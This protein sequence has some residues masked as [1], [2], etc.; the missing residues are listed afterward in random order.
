MIRSQSISYLSEKK[1]SGLFMSMIGRKSSSK[2]L[3]S[4]IGTPRPL[5]QLSETLN[6]NSNISN[7]SKRKSMFIPSVL[8]ENKE[9]SD[10]DT[11]RTPKDI[12]DSKTKANR[13]LGLVKSKTTTFSSEKTLAGF[14]LE[15]SDIIS[16]ETIP[17]DSPLS[18]KTKV[19]YGD[20]AGAGPIEY[21][22]YL[23]NYVDKE[24]YPV[25]QPAKLHR[26]VNLSAYSDLMNSDPSRLPMGNR[27]SMKIEAQQLEEVR[28]HFKSQ[29][30]VK[31]KFVEN[32]IFLSFF[33]NDDMASNTPDA[34]PWDQVD[35]NLL[36][37][38]YD[39]DDKLYMYL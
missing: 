1:K 38:E 13:R 12:K 5:S 4:L 19:D 31:V 27:L 23:S 25:S 39:S 21:P 37:E 6:N 33:D 14:N 9:N 2:D 15:P 17:M 32:A 8:A 34:R 16:V 7:I 36:N 30:D 11:R 35:A 28:K 24:E 26:T 20:L 3:N 29:A 18:Q 10:M 22:S